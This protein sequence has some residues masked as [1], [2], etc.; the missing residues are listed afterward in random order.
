M[1]MPEYNQGQ[2]PQIDSMQLE[3]YKYYDER[4]EPWLLRVFAG[5]QWGGGQGYSFKADVF[6]LGDLEIGYTQLEVTRVTER[7][8]EYSSEGEKGK[9][10]FHI[11]GKGLTVQTDSPNFE[12][13]GFSLDNLG[14]YQLGGTVADPRTFNAISGEIHINFIEL[15]KGP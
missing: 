8:C 3:L 10:A 1:Q 2:Y 14:K 9:I 4:V 12:V 7:G 5:T 13:H 15:F 6:G 11:V